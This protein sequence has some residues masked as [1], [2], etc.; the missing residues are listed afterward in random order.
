MAQPATSHGKLRLADKDPRIVRSTSAADRFTVT[1]ALEGTNLLE[2]QN[3]LAPRIADIGVEGI[4]RMGMS[5]SLYGVEQGRE[6]EVLNEVQAAI[7]DV[8]QARD[9]AREETRDRHS[10]AEAAQAVSEEQLEAVRK[11]FQAA[12]AS[13]EKTD[14]G[15]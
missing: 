9:A 6:G 11:S 15:T 2:L 7:D 4:S 1:F 3:A 5:M 10:A 13:Q 14:A 8:N 12:R